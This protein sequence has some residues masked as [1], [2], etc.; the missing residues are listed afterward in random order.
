M[1]AT[2]H[3]GETPVKLNGDLPKVGDKAPAF[4]VVKEDMSELSLG[5]I[6][7]KATVLTV[8]PSLDTPVCQA[9]TRKF[10]EEID[11][12]AGAFGVV[13]SK[14]L[15]FAMK[16]FCETEGIIPALEPSHAIYHISTL[17]PNL[18]KDEIILLGLSGRGDKDME[19]VAGALGVEA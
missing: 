11:K 4:R 19:T 18:G 14:D 10:N 1:A 5:D 15:P 13:V 16:R 17:A 6:D 12:R 2:T 7:A 3:L 8:V 9:Q